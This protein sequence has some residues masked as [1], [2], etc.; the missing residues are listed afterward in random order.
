MFKW[1]AFFTQLHI[2]SK[3]YVF[4]P[5]RR[6]Y[7][8]CFARHCMD[9]MLTPL[10][11]RSSKAWNVQ[12]IFKQKLRLVFCSQFGILFPF[13]ACLL[14]IVLLIWPREDC[15][16]S[17][18]AGKI[19]NAMENECKPT[20]SKLSQKIFL[21][22]SEEIDWLAIPRISL[23]FCL[24]CLTIFALFRHIRTV[25]FATARA[26]TIAKTIVNR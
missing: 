2:Y 19:S 13:F 10:S 7:R 3:Y 17:P 21:V 25:L 23:A 6:R 16:N 14:T 5:L 1:N 20:M 22:S 11:V 18:G 9:L 24:L 15:R 4:S 8:D 26:P 12:I